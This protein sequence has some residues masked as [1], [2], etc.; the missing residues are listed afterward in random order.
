MKSPFR[1]LTALALLSVGFSACSKPP[2]ALIAEADK[3]LEAAREADAPDYD[4]PTYVDAVTAL[5]ESRQLA[6]DG[7]NSK[8][9]AA[10]QLAKKTGEKALASAQA[11]KPEA[12]AKFP[13]EQKAA[14]AAL[15][16]F[17]TSAGKTGTNKDSQQTIEWAEKQ[18]GDAESLVKEE[19]YGRALFNVRMVKNRLDVLKAV[20]AAPAAPRAVVPPKK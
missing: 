13:E 3:V 6:Q 1:I 8:A 18:L 19:R 14:K 2:D 9:R 16:E 11:K 4:L 10:A 20:G 12:K 15:A 5:M 17:K 7:K